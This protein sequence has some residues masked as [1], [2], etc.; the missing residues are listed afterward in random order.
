MLID[1]RL[2]VVVLV[3][4]TEE[5]AEVVVDGFESIGSTAPSSPLALSSR[6]LIFSKNASFTHLLRGLPVTLSADLPFDDP[7]PSP[8]LL[9]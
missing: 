9:P 8:P 7:S 6:C 2:E 5:E 1:D 3:G 4:T